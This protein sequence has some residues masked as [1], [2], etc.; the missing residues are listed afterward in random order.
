MSRLTVDDAN[1]RK[2]GELNCSQFAEMARRKLFVFF[3]LHL[4]RRLVLEMH[5]LT[6]ITNGYL[7]DFMKC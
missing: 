4:L 2:Y 5:K 6:G 1:S 7:E 3:N